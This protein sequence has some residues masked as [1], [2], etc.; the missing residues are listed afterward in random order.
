LRHAGRRARRPS[1]GRPAPAD[2]DRPR[3]PQGPAHPDP[4]RGDVRPGRRERV[5]RAAGLG[6]THGEPHR[7]RDRAPAVDRPP[8]RPHRGHPRGAHRGDRAPRRADRARWYLP[9]ALRPPDGGRGLTDDPRGGR[10]APYGSRNLLTMGRRQSR[11]NAR[12]V[13]FTPIGPWR[14]LYS[15]RSTIAMTFRTTPGSKPLATMSARLRSSST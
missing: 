10:R 15:F 1:L 4:R 9:E 14:R 8:R 3:L 7:P 6:R 12:G 2:R 13:I 5:P 11:P